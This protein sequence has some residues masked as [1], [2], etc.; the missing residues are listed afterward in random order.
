MFV[1]DDTLAGWVM[2][3]PDGEPWRFGPVDAWF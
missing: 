1:W 3:W 2:V